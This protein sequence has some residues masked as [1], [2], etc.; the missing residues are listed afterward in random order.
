MRHLAFEITNGAGY[1]EQE[2]EER[3]GVQNECIPMSDAV[4]EAVKVA[5]E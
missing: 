3:N 2:A 1:G 5:Q 4:K